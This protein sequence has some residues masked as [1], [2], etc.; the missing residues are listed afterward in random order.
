MPIYEY[1]CQRCSNKFE[2]IR[3]VKDRDNKIA[4]PQCGSEAHRVLSPVNF[5]FGWIM[6]N[7]EPFTP[8]LPRKNV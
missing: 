8:D 6:D 7:V 2:K 1:K 5:T 4:C 3:R